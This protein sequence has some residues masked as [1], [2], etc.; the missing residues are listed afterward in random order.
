[1]SGAVRLLDLQ[2]LISALGP[3]RRHQVRS[4]ADDPGRTGHRRAHGIPQRRDARGNQRAPADA[5]H[6]QI[7]VIVAGIDCR[8][9]VRAVVLGDQGG[10]ERG[11]RGETDRRLPRRQRDAA[12]GRY[13]HPQ[14]G[15]A[16]GA[17]GDDDAVEIGEF[18]LREVHHA[19]NERHH[20]LGVAAHHRQRLAGGD[21]AA[22]E[23]GGRAGFEGGVDGKDAHSQ[24]DRSHGCGRRTQRT[25]NSE[26][27]SVR[28]IRHSLFAIRFHRSSVFRQAAIPSA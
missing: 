16:A 20:R 4:R 6:L 24:T 28:A 23:H 19:R 5:E 7:D 15:K 8:H 25:A 10:R 18:D 9:H 13:S 1:M 3:R 14:S 11:E 21:D 22:D 2:R 12:G 17:G 26:A 27:N